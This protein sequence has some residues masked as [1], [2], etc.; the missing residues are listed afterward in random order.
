P[1]ERLR[2]MALLFADA[3]AAAALPG[4]VAADSREA[5]A[6]AYAVSLLNYAAGRYG[7]LIDPGRSHALAR[8]A[9]DETL[10]RFLRGLSH[11]D[12]LIIHRANPVY[13]RP[14][15]MEKAEQAGTVVYC[16]TLLDETARDADWFLPVADDL[17]AWGDYEPYPGINGLMQP[18]MQPLT[19]SPGI[20]DLLLL[21]AAAAGKPLRRSP[22]G[23]AGASARDWLQARWGLAGSGWE[24]ALRRGGSWPE[25]GARG[26]RTPRIR[27]QAVGV[28]AKGAFDAP[29]NAPEAPLA[30]N[31][32]KLWLW[33]SIMLFDGRGA[34]RGWLQEAPEP[35]S[36]TVWGSWIDIHP[37]KAEKLGIRPQDLVELTAEGGGRIEAP[38]RVTAEVN[39][40]TVALCLGQGHTALGETAAGV[41]VNGFVLLPSPGTGGA[42]DGMFGRATLRRTGRKGAV[43]SALA[44]R[45][46][47]RRDLLRWRTID[48]V[49]R[50]KPGPFTMP[51]PE[52][53]TPERDLYPPH[54][55]KGHRWA[56]AIDLQR[57]IGCGACAVACYAENNI[58]VMGRQELARGREMAWL[59]AVP[60]RHPE[61]PLR[62]GWIPLPC[63]HCDAAPCEPVCPVFASVHNEEGLNA[64][65]YNRCIGTRYCSN[66]CPYKVRRFNWL[67][68]H[69]RDPLQWQLNPEVTVRS[70]G[71]MEKCTFC[72]QRIRNAEYR[73][74]TENRALRDGEVQPAC[75]QSCP[76]R[77]F[78]FGDLL[79]PGA[80]VSRVFRSDPRRYQLLHELNTKPAIAYLYRIEQP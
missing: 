79:D 71:V 4:P 5:A 73:A 53:Y 13:A 8:T 27:P 33:P 50:M 80:E 19:G 77:V 23:P 30:D 51:L 37:E 22:G 40:D 9:T 6:L 75:V 21:L 62:I 59:K 45:E 68:H 52:G 49:R 55:N 1:A 32:A 46:Q 36:F 69:W 16:G 57:C 66:N 70:R 24:E 41:G 56:M 14:L 74:K 58:P 25:K 60:Y 39:P 42:V 43:V 20:G 48:E 11:R 47:H 29:E 67:N 26:S 15:L 38:A 31:R 18:T 12:V 44:T 54:E 10:A 63:Q 2:K 28:Q 76:T 64:Q 61:S 35:V 17:E 34:N 78:T 3:P 7:T 65:I 72:V